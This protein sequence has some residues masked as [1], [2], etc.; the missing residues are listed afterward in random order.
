MIYTDL[1]AKNIEAMK[2]KNTVARAIYSVLIGKLD[3]L[4]VAKREKGQDLEDADCINVIQ[5]TIKE[6]EDEASNFK[7][8]NN[9]A[10]VDAC[11]EQIEYAKAFLP[12]MLSEDEI[13]N[14]ISSLE[15]KSIPFV[16]KHFKSNYAGKCDM[17]L[18]NKVLRS[19]N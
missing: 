11:N 10:K 1:K 14:I 18:V 16:M 17:G 5:K 15:D 3:V 4:K 12:Q 6:L 13:K 7:L 8:V 2:A 9:Q 19:F